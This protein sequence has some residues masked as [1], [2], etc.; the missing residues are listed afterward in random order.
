MSNYSHFTDYRGWKIMLSSR[1]ED[2]WWA[3]NENWGDGSVNLYAGTLA[4]LKISI[5]REIDL[6]PDGDPYWM[7]KSHETRPA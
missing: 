4:A 7:E 6:N 2:S 5:D 3:Y 1:K